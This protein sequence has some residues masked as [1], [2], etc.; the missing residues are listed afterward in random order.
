MLA[1]GFSRRMGKPKL[2]LPL[3]NSTVLEQSVAAAGAA[4][5]GERILVVRE[6]SKD[7]PGFRTIEIGPEA[8][9]GIHRSIR[10]GIEALQPCEAVCIALADQ[11]FLTT[12]D[13]QDL[14]TA[15]AEAKAAGKDLLFPE[16]Q[17]QRGNPAIV[18]SR[19]F[20][21]ILEERDTDKGCQYL[22]RRHPERVFAWATAARGFYQD[23]DDWETY[24]ACRN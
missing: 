1:A 14:L 12:A 9:K 17:G 10:A 15:W 20:R 16:N 8:E 3:G 13:Y 19:Y 18:A 23:L 7:Y 6:K 11:P 24:Q 4:P 21:E 5:F 2:L 22:F